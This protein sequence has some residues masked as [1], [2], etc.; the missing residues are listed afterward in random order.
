MRKIKFD[1][2]KAMSGNYRCETGAGIKV[3]H[4]VWFKKATLFFCL[5]GLRSGELDKW[6]IKGEWYQSGMGKHYH[7]LF[8]IKVK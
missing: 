4:L 8:L 1:I 3:A 2:D 6:T 7:D 5:S